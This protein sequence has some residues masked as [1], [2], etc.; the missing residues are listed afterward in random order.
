M[1]GVITSARTT[2]GDRL[3][4]RGSNV[5]ETREIMRKAKAATGVLREKRA[6]GKTGKGIWVGREE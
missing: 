2:L 6:A 5:K 4:D 3:T 1:G